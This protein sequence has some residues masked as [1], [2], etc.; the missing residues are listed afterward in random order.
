MIFDA[1]YTMN[2]PE[3]I[4]QENKI[5]RDNVELRFAEYYTKHEH[6]WKSIPDNDKMMISNK[7]RE[8]SVMEGMLME[9]VTI[10]QWLKGA[11]SRKIPP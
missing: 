6:L 5:Y 10:E 7:V 4:N 1:Y 2:K 11:R 3:W 8:R 9:A